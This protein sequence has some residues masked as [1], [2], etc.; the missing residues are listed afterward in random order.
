MGRHGTPLLPALGDRLNP[1]QPYLVQT[2]Y[3][4]KDT[5]PLYFVCAL[6]PVMLKFPA[7]VNELQMSDVWEPLPP[8][9]LRFAAGA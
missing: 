9:T 4:T 3:R 7:A 8:A 2:G 1:A 6:P 5:V